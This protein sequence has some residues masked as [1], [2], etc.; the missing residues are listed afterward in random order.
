MG[1]CG[2]VVAV[3]LSA[4]LSGILPALAVALG[5]IALGG[6][7]SC[8][9]TVRVAAMPVIASGSFDGAAVDPASGRVYLADRTDSGI[10][11]VDIGT[12]NPRF[13][14]TLNLNAAPN[15]LA[16]APDQGRLYAGL[17]DGTVAVIDT[18]SMQV[19]DSVLVTTA[20]G[21]DLLDYSPSTH[22]VYAGTGDGGEVVTIDATTNTVG[23]RF[24]AKG[25]VEQPR[26]DPADGRLYVTTPKN[27][28]VLQVD[29]R[30]GNI[31]RTY[32]IPKCEPTGLAINPAR[33][34]AML[35]C[36]SSVA[37][38]NLQTGADTVTREVQGGDI[39][40]YDS[41]ADRFVIASPHGPRD[42]AVGVFSGQGDFIGSVAASPN[43]HAAV[44]DAPRGLVY[45]PGSKGL[46]SFTPAAC[47]PPPDWLQFAGGFSVFAIPFLGLVLLGVA[48]AR[49]SRRPR[50]SSKPTFRDLQDEDLQA[51]R[52]RM[53]ELENGIFG[54]EP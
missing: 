22:S 39:V 28:S 26:Y 43:A 30:T 21:V 5:V 15:G 40:A 19:V 20:A 38:L 42:S 53:R 33:Q 41:A 50:D 13:I 29:P 49:R 54:L 23:Q 16:A 7:A 10:D 1:R 18:R 12:G 25:T 3:P 9:S 37:L 14:G 27:S 46:M 47:A 45:A 24:L 52:E 4:F 8:Q 34:V 31:T 11:V 48:F 44:I 6:C 2:S 35:A 17:E 51:E 32:V 36:G